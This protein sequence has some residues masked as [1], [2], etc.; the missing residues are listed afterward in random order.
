MDYNKLEI[1]GWNK[2]YAI[3]RVNRSTNSF[4]KHQINNGN[5]CLNILSYLNRYYETGKKVKKR[6][7][8]IWIFLL[9]W[10]ELTVFLLIS[11][12]KSC[13]SFLFA[14]NFEEFPNSWLIQTSKE[15]DILNANGCTDWPKG[16][17]IQYDS[18]LSI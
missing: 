5:L 18:M 16:Y 1:A 3:H 11:S 9:L 13:K 4:E 12:R 6:K 14:R 8:S 7:K 2:K 17:P 10:F 15:F